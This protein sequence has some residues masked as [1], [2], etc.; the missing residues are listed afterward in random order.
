MRHSITRTDLFRPSELLRHRDSSWQAI[1]RAET[2]YPQPVQEVLLLT[3]QT[4]YYRRGQVRTRRFVD[5]LLS[6]AGAPDTAGGAAYVHAQ[7]LKRDLMLWAALSSFI[8][9]LLCRAAAAAAASASP[10]EALELALKLKSAYNKD[11]RPPPDNGSAN[12]VTVFFNLNNLVRVDSAAQEIM[13]QVWFS[14]PLG[15]KGKFNSSFDNVS[16]IFVPADLLWQPDV[17]FYDLLDLRRTSSEKIVLVVKSDGLVQYTSELL[18]HS[19][20]EMNMAEFPYD[21]QSCHQRVSSVVHTNETIA[22]RIRESKP[23]DSLTDFLV[24]NID[25]CIVNV[26][27]VKSIDV[28][29][30]FVELRVDIKR[31]TTFYM[32][33]LILP[34]F[35]LLAISTLAFC[36]PPECGERLSLSIT[37]VLSMCVFLQLTG[38]FTPTQGDSVPLLTWYF[39]LA[40]LLTMANLVANAFVLSCH[41]EQ[42]SENARVPGRLTRLLFLNRLFCGHPSR[43]ESPSARNSNVVIEPTAAENTYSDGTELRV[44]SQ[45]RLGKAESET[46]MQHPSF[47][48][49]WSAVVTAADRCFFAFFFSL[50]MSLAL[51]I[52]ILDAMNSKT[53][54]IVGKNN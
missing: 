49:D 6:D 52:A 15:W 34:S 4:P 21:T 43:T 26:S 39:S 40:V 30:D 11:A 16:S 44:I 51:A 2:Y 32:M 17:A 7:A 23:G 27:T 12:L 33:N 31:K 35:L 28:I 24:K 45:R 29:Y 22:L 18:T 10:D 53:S 14:L 38:N 1:I 46:T 13:L 54:C 37:I 36:L 3:L 48:S 20:C 19:K 5:C 8:A 50:T 47:K 25:F 42:F 9:L 41:F